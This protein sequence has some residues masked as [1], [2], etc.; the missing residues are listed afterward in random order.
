M[1]VNPYGRRSGSFEDSVAERTSCCGVETRR[2]HISFETG[3]EGR[4]QGV[5]YG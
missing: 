4:S 5:Y 2:Y 1:D 3:G